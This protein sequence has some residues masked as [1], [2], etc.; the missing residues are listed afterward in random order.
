MNIAHFI[1]TRR[2]QRAQL[3]VEL[4]CLCL[5][6]A[7]SVGVFG[8]EGIG[9]ACGLGLAYAVPRALYARISGGEPWGALV[10]SVSG[11]M[12][13]I[14][15]FSNIYG[16][17]HEVG[18][19]LANPDLHCDDALYFRWALN[20]FDGSVAE[21]QTKFVGFPLMIL[22][23]WRLFGASIVWPIA[24]NVSLTLLTIVVS[25]QMAGRVLARRLTATRTQVTVLTMLGVAVLGY[26]MSHGPM[27]LKEPLTYFSVALAAYALARMKSLDAA[28]DG[29]VWRDV[30]CYTV[31]V[32]VMAV[33]RMSVVYF[34]MIGVLL[35]LADNRKMWRY[36]AALLAVSVVG[37]GLGVYWS[38]GFGSEVQMRIVAGTDI[39]KEIYLAHGAYGEMMSH[40]FQ[41]PMWQRLLLLPVTC[42]VQFFIPFPWP[43]AETAETLS[44]SLLATRFQ[45]V[46]YAVAGLALFYLF[47]Q[48]YKKQSLGWW[49]LWPFVSIAVVAFVTSGS[50]SRYTLPFQPLFVTI[51]VWV[52]CK[53]REG[54]WRGT[55]RIWC[56][57]YAMVVAAVLAYCYAATA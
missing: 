38:N 26:F 54:Q 6:L 35:T 47:T 25:G 21:P 32:M 2:F 29:P 28:H 8:T 11:I 40:Y 16:W 20:H 24:I 1:L 18:R 36:A 55:F 27:L 3:C 41:Q 44:V 19:T 49:A 34:L 39:M 23:S 46:W 10:M 48:S 7:V 53:Y 14:W 56:A 37:V 9:L 50:V 15:A 52:V 45:W 17:T 22:L 57:C 51:A 42:A 13:V 4:L 30:V 31:A 33:T 12:L 5:L 43:S